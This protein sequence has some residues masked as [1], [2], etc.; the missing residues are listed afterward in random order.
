MELNALQPRFSLKHLTIA[1]SLIA[2]GLSFWMWKQKQRMAGARQLAAE[3]DVGILSV[4]D[5][6]DFLTE[7]G[8]AGPAFTRP[9]LAE[10]YVYVDKDGAIFLDNRPV[11]W[12]GATQWLIA[13]KR[14][15]E[16][17][18]IR[19]VHLQMVAKDCTVGALYGSDR[20]LKTQVALMEF[21]EAEGFASTG[22]L[23]FEQVDERKRNLDPHGLVGQGEPGARPARKPR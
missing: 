15:A 1:V 23:E 21:A 3:S 2:I 9:A 6:P 19:S 18:G 10:L 17:L 12:E 22:N 8:L 7:S 13:K 20:G 11:T 16:Q 5:A 14:K 4:S